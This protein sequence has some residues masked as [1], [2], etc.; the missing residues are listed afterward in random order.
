VNMPQGISKLS[1]VLHFFIWTTEN[2]LKIRPLSVVLFW[3]ISATIYVC[4]SIAFFLSSFHPGTFWGICYSSIC[5]N[6]WWTWVETWTKRV[7]LLSCLC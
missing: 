6:M 3:Q 2:P 1:L 7:D 5:F 4:F